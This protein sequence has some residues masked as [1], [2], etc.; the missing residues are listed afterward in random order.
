MC[1]LKLILFCAC[2]CSGYSFNVKWSNLDPLD[3]VQM[4]GNFGDNVQKE[5]ENLLK[6]VRHLSL[7]VLKTL[8]VDMG[9]I[10]N[11][12]FSNPVLGSATPGFPC[13]V[14]RPRFFS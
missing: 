14:E 10:P 12:P 7:A 6:R 8:I 3:V 2:M 4:L 9:I 1:H 5:F 11:T 13:L